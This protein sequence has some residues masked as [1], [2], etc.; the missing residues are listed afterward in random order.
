MKK[1]M[2]ITVLLALACLAVA[3]AFSA[4]GGPG[5]SD[6][7]SGGGSGGEPGPGT[8]G[9]G[10]DPSGEKHVLVFVDGIPATCTTDG[11]VEYWKCTDCGKMFGDELGTKELSE[12]DLKIPAL[13]HDMIR[14][15]ETAPSCTTEGNVLYYECSRCGLLFS[16]EQG[17]NE[18]K[19]EDVVLPVAHDMKYV[20]GVSS[21]CL[22]HGYLAHYECEAC[23]QL[24]MDEEG[25]QAVTTEDIT[26]PLAAHHGYLVPAAPST[27]LE[28]G[29]I[30]HA[31]C[32]VCGRYY[33][34]MTYAEELSE[35][36]V[37]L[38]LGDHDWSEGSVLT[39]ETCTTDGVMQ[40]E[41]TVCHETRTEPIPKHHTSDGTYRSD[42]TI[43]W[44][45]CSVCHT[46][47]DESAH[48][49]GE[50]EVLNAATCT[51]SG[52]MAHV[53]TVCGRMEIEDIPATGHTFVDDRIA[54][55][56]TSAGCVE[57]VCSDC[58]Y[59]YATD[60]TP[61]LEHTFVE[62][63]SVE[64]TCTTD[65]YTTY[66]CSVCGAEDVKYV[67]ATGE[68]DYGD[69][70][71]CSVCG[72]RRNTA[73]GVLFTL[74]EDRT[75]YS[76]S[77]DETSGA[78]EI[79][80]PA[81]FVGED[82]AGELPV[83]V[84][85][86]AF[87]NVGELTAVTLD[88]TPVVE[89][90]AFNGLSLQTLTLRGIKNVSSYYGLVGIGVLNIYA[91]GETM[92]F[93]A[94][95]AENIDE[96]RFAG[97]VD[98]WCSFG[99][100]SY[101]YNPMSVAKKYYF[102]GK[103]TT[104]LV[105][106]SSVESIK[107]YAFYGMKGLKSVTFT[108]PV[109][110]GS[111]AFGNCSGVERVYVPSMSVWLHSYIDTS[112][113]SGEDVLLVAAGKEV[114]ELVVPY[115]VTEIPNRAFRNYDALTSVVMHA[116]VTKIGDD[117]FNDCGSLESVTIYGDTAIGSAAFR[118][119]S[120]LTSLN[121]TGG[122]SIGSM[123]FA[124]CVSLEVVDLPFVTSIDRGAFAECTS[125]TDI[126]LPFVGNGDPN[127]EYDDAEYYFGYVFGMTSADGCAEIVPSSYGF[128]S[129]YVPYSL[130]SVTIY[131]GDVRSDSV[132]NLRMVNEI[133]LGDDVGDVQYG[134]FNGCYGLYTM[135]IGRVESLSSGALPSRFVEI[136]NLTGDG[137]AQLLAK[138]N[139]SYKNYYSAYTPVFAKSGLTVQG[140][141]VFAYTDAGRTLV[142]YRGPYDIDELVLPEGEPYVVGE[143]VFRE[144]YG[145]TRI[146]TS[147]SVTAMEDYAFY[148]N[149]AP[150]GYDFDIT[151]SEGLTEIGLYAFANCGSINSVELPASIEVIYSDAFAGS[152]VFKLGYAG[153][154]DEWCSVRFT[155]IY[156]NPLFTAGSLRVDGGFVTDL[157]DLTVETIGDFAF[158]GWNDPT[159]VDNVPRMDVTISANVKTLGMH[160]FE[161]SALTSVTMQNGLTDIGINAFYG[162]ASLGSVSIPASVE[163]IGSNAFGE[164][165][166]LR[167]FSYGGTLDE[168]CAVTITDI[169][170]NPSYYTGGMLIN[171]EKVTDLSALTTSSIGACAFVGWDVDEIVI[172]EC[173]DN[174][175]FAAFY[176]SSAS[177]VRL[178]S[179]LTSVPDSAFAYCS[180]LTDIV[181]PDGVTTIGSYAFAYCC[182]LSEVTIPA[183]V[184]HIG[185][186]AFNECEAL[187][188]V[189][190]EDVAAWASV[191][192][193][194]AESNPLSYAG[195]LAKDGEI[196]TVVE[197]PEGITEVSA[198]AFR[199][200]RADT[201][202][203]PEGLEI[204]GAY[205]FER[206]DIDRVVMP[207]ARVVR[208]GAFY[209]ATI[210]SVTPTE[211][212]ELDEFVLPEGLESVEYQAFYMQ[213][214]GK[215]IYR[216]TLPSTLKA[217]GAGA[218]YFGS[219]VIELVYDESMADS[220]AVYNFDNDNDVLR[221]S[222]DGQ[223][224]LRMTD[225]RLMFITLLDG[226]PVLVG[227]EGDE[228][229]LVLPEDYDNENYKINSRAFYGLTLDSLTVANGTLEVGDALFENGRVSSITV[230]YLG[231]TADDPTRS[232]IYNVFVSEIELT[233]GGVVYGLDLYSLDSLTLPAGVTG[234][235][236][237]P[238]RMDA[239][240]VPS[241]EFLRS[242]PLPEGGFRNTGRHD[243]Y[244]DGERVFDFTLPVDLTAEDD[245]RYSGFSF[246][247]V[248]IPAEVTE[249]NC[250]SAALAGC[251]DIVRIIDLSPEQSGSANLVRSAD[252]YLTSSTDDA[253]IAL[254][255]NGYLFFR[256]ESG[257]H[258]SKLLY[259]TGD[260][261]ELV[262]PTLPDGETYEIFRYAFVGKNIASVV[263]PEGVTRIGDHAFYGCASL[264]SVALPDSMTYIGASAFE[265]TQAG[266]E[267]NGVVY[268]GKWA[269]G[270]TEKPTT[271]T[272]ADGTS[273]VA[274]EAFYRLDTLT[275]VTLPDGLKYI[276]DDAFAISSNITTLDL[277]TTVVTVGDRAF[278]NCT[279]IATMTDISTLTALEYIGEYAFGGIPAIKEL[280]LPE[281]VRYLGD[282]AF[283]SCAN[284]TS[285][286]LP[287]YLSHI[288]FGAFNECV[289]LS[290]VHY[291]VVV[292]LDPFETVNHS[293]FGSTTGSRSVSGITLTV[294]DGVVSLPRNLFVQNVYVRSVYIPESVKSIGK[295]AFDGCTGLKSATFEIT[296]GWEEFYEYSNTWR[297]IESLA[298][299][300]DAAQALTSHKFEW[301]HA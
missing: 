254:D 266:E 119:C 294:G 12:S 92:T 289:S 58:G 186:C 113:I 268:V 293:I 232:T 134:A 260:A 148:G 45:E 140:D 125:I 251:E 195:Y 107:A 205:A 183:S 196:L 7:G 65:G 108:S 252:I 135:E 9:P 149:E 163:R 222:S 191:E 97:G 20:D 176:G 198:Y 112:L 178:P 206:S 189:N 229:D 2:W 147:T 80:I 257:E 84:E 250:V 197:I 201:V 141:F 59:S 284:L 50:D 24:F 96:V 180:S 182:A 230:P 269:I 225:D 5:G 78:T 172:P 174:I 8:D 64:P 208:D 159:F 76:A 144:M 85:T 288:G 242:I 259:Y 123:A 106:P 274:E 17:E 87:R 190:I 194:T 122:S 203:L 214:Y 35:E 226:T 39:P 212:S 77:Y 262:L 249:P 18:V 152:D 128:Y 258:T 98:D 298:D 237:V 25:T 158:A 103:E 10:T 130:R 94:S 245:G 150:F 91:D 21:T 99:V 6:G 154:L 67:A 236:S 217:T 279:S 126:R 131:G 233:G 137:D 166:S 146:V 56:C 88:G 256:D 129:F 121:V 133:V 23:G 30:E 160:A 61:M 124:E 291:D 102:A 116:G 299:P 235:Y 69:G 200:L 75:Y 209:Y 13:T 31:Y 188:Q 202:I 138:L 164:C 81:V 271:L 142:G 63:G 219:Q 43:H 181:I 34:D 118:G 187:E 47:Y 74:S 283:V 79:Y 185:E 292:E 175:G 22:D 145:L 228:K 207:S 44:L 272:L 216:V 204:V 153:T 52:R 300:A 227:Y 278:L 42:G 157:S 62:T 36:D 244:V 168:W 231:K 26:L 95:I 53:C 287:K 4:C 93:G 193:R 117:A 276:G 255:E 213:T 100:N 265:G 239:L 83:H 234:L 111:L 51:R 215:P 275:S 247:S 273:G 162:C 277:P 19:P 211:D 243:L 38:P 49:W 29:H 27:C 167:S 223:S 143:S 89:S 136:R 270:Y 114:T 32:P 11:M 15:D 177:S 16:D 70:D 60:L 241:L 156:A 151:L 282:D 290:E 120:A 82:V 40:Y 253:S 14:H 66:E 263:I 72:H 127:T 68:H 71:V 179:G 101:S 169:Y 281:S 285:V 286:T 165:A 132:S 37:L 297:A 301:R 109:N 224:H 28:Q 261:T 110:S 173:V 192:F 161:S 210:D 264:T 73:D 296:E 1:R 90:G 170:A 86:D 33:A 139:T 199:C 267:L 240:Y 105:I 218:F 54:A 248:T 57:H 220:S 238:H 171:G 41:C 115:D 295:N 104:D 246:L 3:L 280:T 155:N 48:K 221:M 46:V 184:E 55:S